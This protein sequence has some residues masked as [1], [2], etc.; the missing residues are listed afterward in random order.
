MKRTVRAKLALRTDTLRTLSGSELRQ[1]RGG[2]QCY[3]ISALV[4]PA[5]W[6]ASCGDS[7]TAELNTT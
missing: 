4:C 2:V 6:C 3:T 5:T 7:C 1:P